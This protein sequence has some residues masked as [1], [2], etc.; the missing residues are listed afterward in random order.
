MYYGSPSQ[1]MPSLF[2]ENHVHFPE[3][4]N[5]TTQP[6]EI[7]TFLIMICLEGPSFSWMKQRVTWQVIESFRQ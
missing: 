4:T 1:P 6:L 2:V 3:G 5:K 7:K